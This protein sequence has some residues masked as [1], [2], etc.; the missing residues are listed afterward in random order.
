[1]TLKTNGN[2][3]EITYNGF[4]IEL[5][6]LNHVARVYKPAKPEHCMGEYIASFDVS[7]YTL[8]QFCQ[9]LKEL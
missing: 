2:I 8:N 3:A 9:L 6:L 1:M 7:K 5:D 4:Y